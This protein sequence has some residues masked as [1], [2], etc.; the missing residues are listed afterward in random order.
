MITDLGVMEPDTSTRELTLTACHPG[1]TVDQVRAATGWPL[2]VADSVGTTAAP[3]A[4]ELAALR[5]LEERTKEAHRAG[6]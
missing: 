3:T 2:K 4:A 6:S 1:V 5:E